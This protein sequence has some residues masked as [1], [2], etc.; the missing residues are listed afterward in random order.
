[1]NIIV[2][3]KINNKHVTGCMELQFLSKLYNSKIIQ[4]DTYNIVRD[5]ILQEYKI[6]S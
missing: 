3:N 2:N 5:T 6:M 4:E 1:M